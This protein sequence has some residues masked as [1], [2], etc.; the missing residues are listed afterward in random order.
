MAPQGATQALP[1]QLLLDTIPNILVSLS[2]CSSAME[3]SIKVA[4]RHEIAAIEG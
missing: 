4:D 2:H 1:K 3:K